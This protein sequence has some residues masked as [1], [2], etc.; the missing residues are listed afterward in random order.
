MNFAINSGMDR[1][2]RLSQLYGKTNLIDESCPRVGELIEQLKTEVQQDFPFCVEEHI[3]DNFQK[4]FNLTAPLLSCASCGVRQFQLGLES[5]KNYQKIP[6]DRLVKLQLSHQ[7]L[8]TLLAIPLP[9]RRVVSYF[10]SSNGLYYH[11]HPEFVTATTNDNTKLVSEIA[12]VCEKCHAVLVKPTSQVPKWSIAAGIDFGN[13]GR[14]GLPPLRL[15]EEYVIAR[16]RLYVSIV[17]LTGY[18]TASRQHAKQGHVISFPQ[19]R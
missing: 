13:P 14:I 12:T 2:H 5:A 4:M 9:Y 17:K 3:V 7:Q 6:I 11:L 19:V 16:V 15:A 8:E 18:T 1:F 10:Q